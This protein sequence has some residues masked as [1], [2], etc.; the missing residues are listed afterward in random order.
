[1]TTLPDFRLAFVVAGL[2]GLSS[3]LWFLRLAPDAGA[4]VTGHGPKGH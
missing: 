2:V 1:M 3:V 4:E